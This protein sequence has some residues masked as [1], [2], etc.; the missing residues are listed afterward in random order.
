MF[1]G[2]FF[3]RSSIQGQRFALRRLPPPPPRSLD[4]NVFAFTFSSCFG[5]F[6]NFF[7]LGIIFFFMVC[8]CA[9]APYLCIPFY[10]VVSMYCICVVA[11]SPFYDDDGRRSHFV[12]RVCRRFFEKW[13]CLFRHSVGEAEGDGGRAH[14]TRSWH[15]VFTT[16]PCL[17]TRRFPP[18]T[19]SV[20]FP[21]RSFSTKRFSSISFSSDLSY[22]PVVPFP[23]RFPI[24]SVQL[25]RFLLHCGALGSFKIY[26]PSPHPTKR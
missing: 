21:S 4:R 18:P 10:D 5:E 25:R 23:F 17:V 22:L 24:E 6:R 14:W 13:A 8:P 19:S 1:F 7:P 12:V 20:L 26:T 16:S 15:V 3:I 9:A 11:A 2:F